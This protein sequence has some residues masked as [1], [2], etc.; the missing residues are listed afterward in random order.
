VDVLDF[1]VA[2]L[3]VAAAWSGW[4][5]GAVWVVLSYAGLAFGIAFGAAIA[6]A[7]ARGL[8]DGK[9]GAESLIATLAFLICATVF[10]GA[11]IFL[12][13]RLRVRT[14]VARRSRAGTVAGAGIGVLGASAAL[15]YLGLCFVNFGQ[16]PQLVAQIQ[17]SALLGVA[18][19]AAP[20]PPAFLS[21]LEAQLGNSEFPNPFAGLA[22]PDLPD[23]AVPPAG[24]LEAAAIGRVR[25]VVAKV[26]ASG[27]CGVE[28]GSSWPL[29]PDLWVTNAHVVAGSRTVILLVPG[30]PQGA[31]GEVVRFDPRVDLAIIRASTPYA[32][33]LPRSGGDPPAGRQGAI[34]GYPGG[35]VEQAVVAAVNGEV[36]AQGRDIY[37]SGLVTR[38]IEVLHGVVIPGNSGGPLVDL[39]GAV[40]GVIFATNLG[41]PGEAYALAPSTIARDVG[42]LHPRAPA[43]GTGG[44]AA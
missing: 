28:S 20:R 12:G 44:C 21:R 13:Y 19:S 25:S 24:A 3:L 26:I 4:R 40:I 2:G 23:A 11:G 30:H 36:P 34:V 6:P 22:P 18:D 14:G 33:P 8:G 37:G 29:A 1:F 16:A 17:N 27:P 7:I 35:G 5:R 38:Q 10:Q 15:W 42:S 9:H 39:Q 41:R 32:T 43:V 31:P